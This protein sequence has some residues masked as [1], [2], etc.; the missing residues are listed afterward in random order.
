MCAWTWSGAT[1]MGIPKFVE[2]VIQIQILIQIQNGL[3]P[4][5]VF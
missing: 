3:Y 2:A 4:K 5:F 1:P